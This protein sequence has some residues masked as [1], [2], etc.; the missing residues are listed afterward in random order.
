M[1]DQDLKIQITSEANLAA[2]DQTAKGLKDI[3]KWMEENE[4]WDDMNFWDKIR[5]FRASYAVLGK[6][7]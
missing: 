2:V 4:R 6:K 3:A 1:A 5:W 7:F